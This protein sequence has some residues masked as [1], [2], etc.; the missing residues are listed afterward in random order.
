MNIAWSTRNVAFTKATC[1]AVP[2]SPGAH[3]MHSRN[4]PQGWPQCGMKWSCRCLS[5]SPHSGTD[6]SAQLVAHVSMVIALL[7]CVH[8]VQQ[9]VQLQASSYACCVEAAC[10]WSGRSAPV[11]LQNPVSSSLLARSLLFWALRL[12][13][14]PARTL[15]VTQ[16]GHARF[17]GSTCRQAT[18]KTGQRC[19]QISSRGST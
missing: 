5:D 14:M 12:P 6:S 9:G 2:R 7:Q 15:A 18:R 8:C 1:H 17:G 11:T 13:Q 4:L 10:T 19:R 3:R 16:R